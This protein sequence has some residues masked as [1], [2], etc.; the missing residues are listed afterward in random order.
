MLQAVGIRAYYLHVDSERGVINPLAPSL[1][2]N[3]MITAIELPDGESDPRLQA[4]VKDAKGKTLL[5]FDP[6]DEE[7]PLGL[8]RGELQGAY[9]NLANGTD[10][11]VLQMPV[12]LP[13]SAELSRKGSFV[14]SADGTLSGDITDI[15]SG[16]DAARERGF[17]KERDTKEVHDR[18]EEASE[19]RSAQ[20]GLQ[21]V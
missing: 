19:L 15:F 13:R 9:G 17:L 5:I 3:H 2:G 6:T 1:M 12:L 10:S 20:P 4:V 21:R 14:L 8:I 7:T 11:A 16:V 18:L